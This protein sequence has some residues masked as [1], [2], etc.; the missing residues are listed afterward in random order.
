MRGPQVGVSL[1]TLTWESGSARAL[2]ATPPLTPLQLM[3]LIPQGSGIL[4][5][6]SPLS[7]R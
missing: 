5:L 6:K 4:T 3:G 2:V 7:P 1:I